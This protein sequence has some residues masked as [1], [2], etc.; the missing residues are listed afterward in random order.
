MKFV[1][2]SLGEGTNYRFGFKKDDYIIDTI[3]ASIWANE[4]LGDF[5][6]LEIPSTLKKSLENW[7]ENFKK[8]QIYD[9]SM[10]EWAMNEDL[11]IETDE[12]VTS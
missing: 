6:Y 1:T 3:R 8:L 12:S 5:S 4:N 2:Y 10:S 11:P 9:N 7:D